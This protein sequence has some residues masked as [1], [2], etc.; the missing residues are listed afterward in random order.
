LK[1]AEVERFRN[2]LVEKGLAPGTINHC[3]VTLDATLNRAVR[4]ELLDR[5]PSRVVRKL[6]DPS[7][8]MVCLSEEQAGQLVEVA[9]GTRREAL[10]ALAL[11]CGLRQGEILG[12]TWEDLKD[13]EL[14]VRRS[15]DTTGPVPRWGQTKGKE[16]RAITLPESLLE[17]LRRHRKLQ[18]EE[19]LAAP[20]WDDMGFVFPDERRRVQR[21]HVLLYQLRKDLEAAGLPR[22]RF[23]DLRDSSA[24]LMLGHHVPLHVVAKILG[25]KDPALT[26]RRYA[27]VLPDA[28]EEAARR[29]ETYCF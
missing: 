28:R 15:V 12:L 19:R 14:A 2:R 4:W 16:G 26:L 1:P 11:K 5:N 3:L 23:H 9:R 10:Y 6:K 8:D 22:I 20:F 29:M 27:H 25:H 24:T 18:S 7:S 17:T 21:G 13:T